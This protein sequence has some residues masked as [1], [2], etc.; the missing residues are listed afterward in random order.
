MPVSLDVYN[1][2]GQ[3][4][5]RLESGVKAP[6]SYVSVWNGRDDQ[7]RELPAEPIS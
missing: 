4:L 3:K 5:R 6:G 7:N 2:R 1:L